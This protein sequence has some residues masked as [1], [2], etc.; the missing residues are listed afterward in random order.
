MQWISAR[1][2]HPDI[3]ERVII[4][5]ITCNEYPVISVETYYGDRSW[6]RVRCWLPL[7]PV[8]PNYLERNLNEY[9]RKFA[10]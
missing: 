2:R 5:G 6:D 8:P 7:P 4:Y 1:E 3:G 10:R 9:A